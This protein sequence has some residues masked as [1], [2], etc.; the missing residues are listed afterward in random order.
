M[1]PRT[2]PG[3]PTEP[4]DGGPSLAVLPTGVLAALPV[5]AV[6]GG[7]LVWIVAP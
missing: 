4:A 7:V 3:R 1:T 5:G 6:L 2:G